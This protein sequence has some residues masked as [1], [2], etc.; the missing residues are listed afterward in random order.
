MNTPHTILVGLCS[1]SNLGD[2]A[3]M[4]AR[5]RILQESLAETRPGWEVVR[6]EMW[7]EGT[8]KNSLAAGLWRRL[9]RLVLLGWRKEDSYAMALEELFMRKVGPATRAISLA[10]GM[11]KRLRNASK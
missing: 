9:I 5:C 10:A 11:G 2:V 1:E 7:G 3:P 4:D 8:V 6:Y